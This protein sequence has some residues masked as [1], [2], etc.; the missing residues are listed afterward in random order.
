MDKQALSTKARELYDEL[1]ELM[2]KMRWQAGCLANEGK[3]SAEIDAATATKMARYQAL[4]A[5]RRENMIA[6]F[7]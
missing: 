1:D 2:R 7:S 6:L 4:A 3:S 5:E